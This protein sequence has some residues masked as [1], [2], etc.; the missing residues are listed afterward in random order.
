MQRG[1]KNIHSVNRVIMI[2]RASLVGRVGGI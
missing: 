2:I 1:E